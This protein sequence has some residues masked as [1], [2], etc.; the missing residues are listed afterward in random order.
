MKSLTRIAENIWVMRF[1]LR[2]LG[3]DFD[4]NVTII[5]LRDGRL[6]IHS[7]APFAADDLLAIREL[8]TPAWLLDATLFHDSYA[9]EGC[10]AFARIPYLAP[11]GFPQI[12]DVSTGPLDNPPSDWSGE[13]EVME[14]NG[15]P[16]VREHVF[17]HVPSRTLIVCD[18][19]FNFQSAQHWW[20]RFFV[21]HVMRL[22]R[23]IGTSF[24]MRM[25]INDRSA[26]TSS[27]G[28]MMRWDFD[29]LV[30]GH[31]DVVESGAKAVVRQ[32]LQKVV[33]EAFS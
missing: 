6:I 26:F 24:F 12:A 10:R 9:K 19:V 13:V 4:R 18:L 33:P 3:I 20:E 25:M 7:T 31:G 1:P 32:A 11:R 16:K 5:R 15:V 23:L 14:I 22:H 30:V 17:F 8:G 29:R 27:V 2:L 21:H 28:E